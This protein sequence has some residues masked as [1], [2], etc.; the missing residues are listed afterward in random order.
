MKVLLTGSSRGLGREILERLLRHDCEVWGISRQNPETFTHPKF[1]PLNWDLGDSAQ[2][3]KRLDGEFS[4]SAFD[5][6]IHNAGHGIGELS[7]RSNETNRHLLFGL[8][9]EAPLL[10][11]NFL[12]ERA[13]ATGSLLNIVQI[14][15]L[16][17]H[18]PF[19]GL[20]DYSASKAAVE[21]LGRVYVKEWGRF[22]IDVLNVC[23]DYME[24]DMTAAVDPSVKE[25]IL[26][27]SVDQKPLLISTVA[28]YVIREILEKKKPW[29]GKSVIIS[30]RPV[31]KNQML[32]CEWI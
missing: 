13:L 23:P 19:R 30:N 6:I 26:A 17:V 11:S 9:Y 16:A 14:S 20:G 10:I 7:L 29:R 5:T 18:V 28:A 22:G 8:H 25:Q 3:K 31:L 32:S 15:S 27:V 1:H 12:I 24:S 21:A 2:L 4:A